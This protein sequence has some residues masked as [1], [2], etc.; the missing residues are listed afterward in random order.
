MLTMNPV[1]LS[2]L[3]SCSTRWRMLDGE[4]REVAAGKSNGCDSV[5]LAVP[6]SVAPGVYQL[7]VLVDATTHGTRRISDGYTVGV[8]VQDASASAPR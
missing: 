2:E 8:V 4:D 5:E 7:Q 6:S 1:G 3:V